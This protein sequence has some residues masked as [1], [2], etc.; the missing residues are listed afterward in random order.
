MNLSPSEKKAVLELVAQNISREL[1]LG[2]GAAMADLVMLPITVVE[3]MLSLD[4]RTIK[5]R[6]EWV[7]LTPSKS[8]VKLS[9]VQAYI[10]S[11]TREPV[12]ERS[13]A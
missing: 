12:K 3:K 4:A 8:A 9:T 10:A 13:A 11:Q 5:K 1:I 7:E 2:G 6:M